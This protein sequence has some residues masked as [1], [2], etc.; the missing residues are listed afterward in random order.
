MH[1]LNNGILLN[2]WKGDLCCSLSV[3]F[4]PLWHCVLQ[5]LATLVPLDSQLHLLKLGSVMGSTLV[6]LL[7]AMSQNS[8]KALSWEIIRGSAYLLSISQRTLCLVA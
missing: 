8:L 3:Q 7:W 2:T 5:I 1:I 4:S 6:S